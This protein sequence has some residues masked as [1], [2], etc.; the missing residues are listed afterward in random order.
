VAAVELLIGHGVWLRRNDFV[1]RFVNMTDELLDGSVLA[2]V[3]WHAAVRALESGQ[4][5]CSGSQAQLLRIVTSI[6]EG[7]PVD[8][9]EAVTSLDEGNLRLVAD[10]VLRAGG[11]AAAAC[12]GAGGG[13][14]R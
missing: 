3:D 14:Q 11:I 4:L 13:D 5:P 1:S 6:V 12:S 10:A 2:W 7:V 9:G 8:L